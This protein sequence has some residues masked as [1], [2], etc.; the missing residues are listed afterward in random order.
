M[1]V[2]KWLGL[3]YLP[4]ISYREDPALYRIILSQSPILWTDINCSLV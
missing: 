4:L 3:D 1:L 2:F